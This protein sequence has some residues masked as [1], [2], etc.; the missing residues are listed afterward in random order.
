MTE[1]AKK[2]L[3]I[4]ELIDPYLRIAEADKQKDAKLLPA[5]TLLF[6]SSNHD[7][8]TLPA[9]E[10][11]VK[12]HHHVISRLSAMAYVLEKHPNDPTDE[13]I[14]N[15]LGE[16]EALRQTLEPD[17][18]DACHEAFNAHMDELRHPRIEVPL[19][20]EKTK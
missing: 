2:I 16:A 14:A 6:S 10:S 18:K 11:W 7:F 3:R 19:G 8:M 20:M 9:A 4:A 17:I 15:W 5:D 12:I 1:R 13:Q